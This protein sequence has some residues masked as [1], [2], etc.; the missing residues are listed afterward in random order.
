MEDTGSSIK[1][2]L[3][4][5]GQGALEVDSPK[6]LGLAD[7]NTFDLKK[8]KIYTYIYINSL[9]LKLVSIAYLAIDNL[10]LDGLLKVLLIHQGYITSGV[11]FTE[12]FQDS[13]IKHFASQAAQL[14]NT[15]LIMEII[16]V[17]VIYF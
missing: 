4:L 10:H 11:C 17:I 2:H 12:L 15:I 16:V 7:S 8:E 1:L 14:F 5:S 13:L 3:Q 6:R 9:H